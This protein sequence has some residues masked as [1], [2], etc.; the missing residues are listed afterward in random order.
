MSGHQDIREPEGSGKWLVWLTVLKQ[1][2]L[3]VG[4]VDFGTR[5]VRTLAT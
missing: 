1:N 2:V 3:T 5:D 4:I